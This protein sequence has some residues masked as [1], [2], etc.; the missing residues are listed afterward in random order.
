[1]RYLPRMSLSVWA[2][3]ALLVGGALACLSPAWSVDQKPLVIN[4]TT[5][6][7]EQL[8]ASNTLNAWTIPS[9][10]TTIR[11][12]AAQFGQTVNILNF[13]GDNTG[14]ADNSAAYALAVASIPSGGTIFFPHGTYLWTAPVTV[15]ANGISI[16]GD[17]FAGT[18]F[19]YAIVAGGPLITFQRAGGQEQFVCSIKDIGFYSDDV[20]TQKT[21]LRVVDNSEFIAEN[22]TTVGSWT[23]A[24]SIGIQVRGRD[25][26]TYRNFNLSCDKPL[27]IEDNP[28]SAID[29]DNTVFENMYL[30]GAGNP[31]VTISSGVNVSNLLFTGYQAWVAGTQGL[32][33]IDSATSTVAYNVV[34]E[35]V[36][37]EQMTSATAYSF[38]VQHNYNLVSLALRNCIADPSQRGARFRKINRVIM[39]NFLYAGTGEA[40]NAD[41]TI[42]SLDISSSFFQDSGTASL[43]GL[44][45][46]FRA[47]KFNALGPVASTTLYGNNTSAAQFSLLNIVGDTASTSPTTG[48]LQITSSG[49]LGVGGAAYVGGDVVAYKSA[50]AQTFLKQK[51]STTTTTV[52]DKD[53]RVLFLL[54]SSTLNAGGDVTW[55]AS[56]DTGVERWAAITGDVSANNGSGATGTVSIATKAAVGDS[57]LTRRL[58]VNETGE[59][60]ITTVGKGLSVKEGSNARMGTATLVGGTVV[61]S[62]TAVTAS[63]RIQLTG[64]S[65]GGTPGWLRVSARSAGTSFTI[66][67]SSG[68]DTSTVAW[69]IF[70]PSP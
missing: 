47:Y 62:T 18:R 40:L 27:S 26:S 37:C 31:C 9:G 5:G 51:N 38:D 33:W 19:K 28:N 46:K 60:I 59:V 41:G 45:E 57:T 49:G 66:T 20:T 68:T 7:Q 55:A 4:Q 67:S 70:E 48:T 34:L 24:T 10:A 3:L 52:G 25:S 36:R 69:I 63:S 29:C 11:T 15:A 43:S 35:N 1:M 8:Q 42:Q 21:F 54:D 17:G 22:L 14:V 23:G 12:F 58:T 61:V 65:D 53:S 13:G 6:K 2:T 30:I 44:T 32:S 50:V 16:A 56:S 64:N 39:D